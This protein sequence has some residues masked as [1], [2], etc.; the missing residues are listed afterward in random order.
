MTD[1]N[2]LKET[3]VGTVVEHKCNKSKK[4]IEVDDADWD[5]LEEDEIHDFEV[6]EVG[7]EL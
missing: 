7:F 3:N 6:V 4:E 5:I 2:E 1:K